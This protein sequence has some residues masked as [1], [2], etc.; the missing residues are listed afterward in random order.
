MVL[1]RK[2]GILPQLLLPIKLN[3]VGKIGSGKQPLVW[4]H[5]QDVLSAIYFLMT[6]ETEEQVF[7]LVAPERTNQATFV[8][9]AS[10]QLK[11]KPVLRLPACTFKLLLGEQSQL[12]L[13][14]QYV[15]PKALQHA[16]FEFQYPTLKQAL[17][18]LLA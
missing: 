13:N 8:H 7:N 16:G 14:G 11:R 6:N 17:Q 4:V 1:G 5:M 9:I 18:N 15:K 12:V 2:G 10:K 3:A